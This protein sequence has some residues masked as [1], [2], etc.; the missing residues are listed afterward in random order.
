VKTVAKK[1]ALTFGDFIASAYRA[2]GSRRAKGFVWLT[3]NAHM[4]LYRERQRF[5]VSRKQ[6]DNLSFKLK[7][8]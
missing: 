8:K 6:H 5:V 2:F 3:V 7:G 4:V 1:S